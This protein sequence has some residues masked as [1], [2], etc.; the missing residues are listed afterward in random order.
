[1]NRLYIILLASAVFL[2][3]ACEYEP[4]GRNFIELTPPLDFIPIEISL[5]DVNPSDTIYVYQSTSLSINIKAPRDLIKADV[6]VD[7]QIFAQMWNKSLS[8]LINP[9]QVSEGVHKIT[10]NAVFTSGTGSLAELMSMEGYGGEL[11]WNIRVIHNA[12]ERFELGYRLNQ[13]GF[14]EIFWKNAVPEKTIQKYTVIK[15]SLQDTEVT[16]NDPAQQYFVDYG[17]VSGNTFYDVRTYM[18]DGYFFWQR[19]TVDKPA[20]GLY[21]EDK[22]LNE[23]RVYW[24]KPFAN[25]RYDLKMDNITIASAL[26]DTT[27]TIPQ[28]FGKSRLFTL[29]TRPQREG[30][31]NHYNKFTA[32]ERFSQGTSLNLP[33]WPLYAYN[34]TENI[35]HS[36]RYSTLIA[37]D[38]STLQE[39]NSLL[40]QGDPWGLA[41][42]GKIASAPHNAT[43][44]AMTGEETLI[45]TDSRFINP[46]IIPSLKG[47]VNTR[48]SA[49]TSDDRFF[50]VQKDSET[51]NV[52]NTLTGGK[53]FEFPFTY[54]T[55]Y[56]IPDFVT[57]SEDGKF[58]CASSENGMEVFEISGTTATLIYTD[59]RH[60]KGALF[61]PSQP[62]KLLLRVG[63]DIEIRRLPGFN[64]VQALDVSASGASICNID[65]ASM[66]LLYFQNDSLRVCKVDNLLQTIFKIRSDDKAAKMFNNKLLTYGNGGISFDIKPY[67]NQ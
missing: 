43:V 9:D 11:S 38:A 49:L 5:N 66:S 20:P 25:A 60:Y 36:S 33:N 64:L 56:N 40:I 13:E 6:M 46:I 12:E 51:C 37:F 63:T 34:R 30:Y 19:I 14:M 41:Y 44:A 21:F 24:D 48:L 47:T 53:I 15:E 65:P 50:V 39:V 16:I 2:F 42:G 23:L 3:Q 67:L 35:I 45:F 4:S 57:V 22:G 26:N 59:T 55:K 8:F 28:L 27:I 18:K 10:I 58:F 1:M 54:Q 31:D 29:E 61:V 52:F 7:G 32:S 17:Y 62:D